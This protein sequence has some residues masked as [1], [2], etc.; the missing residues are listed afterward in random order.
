MNKEEKR[1]KIVE[2]AQK[3]HLDMLKKNNAITD[4]KNG[5][6]SLNGMRTLDVI[7]QLYQERDEH[8]FTVELS[9]LR[10]KLGLEK[11]NDYVERIRL[12]IGELKM[13]IELR[14]FR[15]QTS[16]KKIDWA[17][18]SFINEA[19]AY[20]ESQ[21]IVEIE[22]SKHFIDYMVEKAGYTMVDLAL[23]QKFKTKY[24]YKIYE[25][26]LRY[27]SIPNRT[28][29]S[30]G[31]IKK[32]IGELNAKFGT[33]HSHASKMLEGVN[34]GLNEI[35][36]LTAETIF[37]EYS[38]PEKIFIF[39]WTKDIKVIEP[40]C[41][42]PKERIDEF[43]EWV[44]THTKRTIENK[45]TYRHKIKRLLLDGKLDDW[46]SMYRGMMIHKYGYTSPEVDEHKSQSGKYKNFDKKTD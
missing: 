19:V 7:L 27:Y 36:S 35:Y 26:Y 30:I 25:M 24:G 23:N 40:K 46:E 18:T 13:P 2:K 31:T 17:L 28:N 15:D 42:I 11:N 9:L 5:L 34:R 6:L 37:C 20:K 14:D 1:K 10:K 41:F 16:G 21:H 38:K 33:K 43:V 8:K 32:T 44:M 4:S 39:S 3:Q 12:Y 22:I 45:D 29:N